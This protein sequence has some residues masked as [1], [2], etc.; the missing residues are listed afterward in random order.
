METKKN[1]K[2]L[3]YG[4]L[5]T[6][7][8]HK[9]VDPN[10]VAD[11]NGR[12]IA[13]HTDLEVENLFVRL[14][15]ARECGAD[16]VLFDIGEAIQYPSHPEIWI[17]GCLSADKAR[18]VV[19]RM[20]A[21]GYEVIPSLN[22]ATDHHHWLC[23]Y[24]R[25]V[26]TPE[27]YRVCEDVIRDAW[28]ICGHPATFHLG[29]DEEDM[30]CTFIHARN[31]PTLVA[32]R[33]GDL[34]WHDL[35][36]FCDICRKLGSRPSFWMDKQRRSSYSHDV[37]VKHIGKDVLLMP[38]DY[39]SVYEGNTSPKLKKT[40]D[41]MKRLAEAGYDMIPIG[42]NWML[43]KLRTPE[44][45]TTRENIPNLFAWAKKNLPPE[46]FVGFGAA[47]WAG[48]KASGNPVW[49]EAAELLGEVK[50]RESGQS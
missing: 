15:K 36:W 14:K 45:Q 27:Y 44:R 11:P 24:Q 22:F 37:F 19:E 49:F 18:E 25:M 38:W 41:G 50:A 10:R 47:P 5:G 30:D 32:V 31:Y 34:Y 17:D 35:N 2:W 33:Q 43:P 4:Q 12:Y 20:K 21:M 28:E 7:M 16:T 13:D 9:K 26:S 48:M 39:T 42:S 29:Y 40:I 6:F 46:R 1:F 3:I 8:W 23:E